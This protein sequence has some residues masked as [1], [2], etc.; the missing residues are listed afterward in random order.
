MHAEQSQVIKKIFIQNWE[1]KGFNSDA[2]EDISLKRKE[3]LVSQKDLKKE[4]KKS[5]NNLKNEKKVMELLNPIV[6]AYNED[7]FH[8]IL[9]AVDTLYEDYDDDDFQLVNNNV[10]ENVGES[11]F[12]NNMNDAKF[13]GR[14]RTTSAYNS[15][16]YAGG[17]AS[18]YP[19]GRYA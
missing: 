4:L 5:V 14:E 6:D 9:A 7:N 10:S 12:E 19:Q 2:F 18:A 1:R 17:G 13:S 16:K 3:S 15:I 8:D 11:N